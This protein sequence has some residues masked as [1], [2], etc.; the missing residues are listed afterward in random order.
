MTINTRMLSEGILIGTKKLQQIRKYFIF[1]PQIGYKVMT[2]MRSK[3]IQI[4]KIHLNFV[5]G[6]TLNRSDYRY[7]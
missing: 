2:E 7:F 3:I 5:K 1:H 6:F 4:L